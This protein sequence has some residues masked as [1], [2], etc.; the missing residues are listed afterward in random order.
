LVF[1]KKMH[2][3]PK[4]RVKNNVYKNKIAQP[5]TQPR[6]LKQDKIPLGGGNPIK[7]YDKKD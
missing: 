4:E 1:P 2:Q 7:K 5:A 3:L 6:K